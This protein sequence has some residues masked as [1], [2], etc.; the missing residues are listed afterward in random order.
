MDISKR[1]GSPNYINIP[2]P[3]IK[4]FLVSIKF[5]ITRFDCMCTSLACINMNVHVILLHHD[6]DSACRTQGIQLPFD[7]LAAVDDNIL[8]E[9]PG[10]Q[11][12]LFGMVP[13]SSKQSWGFYF[14]V[15]NLLFVTIHKTKS[16][17][18]LNLIIF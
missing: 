14:E 5:E 1:D 9:S 17:L 18:F 10:L 12:A 15:S 13:S 3:W 4:F 2:N 6:C 11:H 16:I 8:R 7:L